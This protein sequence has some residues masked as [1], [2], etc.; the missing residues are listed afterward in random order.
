MVLSP[1]MSGRIDR[2][3]NDMRAERRKN[4]L[5]R[6]I[7]SY[8][9]RHP[10]GTTLSALFSSLRIKKSVLMPILQEVVRGG[11]AFVKSMRAK[12]GRQVEVITLVVNEA[13]LDPEIDKMKRSVRTSSVRQRIIRFIGNNTGKA[14]KKLMCKRLNGTEY[15]LCSELMRLVKEGLVI[16]HDRLP[17]ES[18]YE[19]AS[20]YVVASSKAEDLGLSRPASVD[21]K[22]PSRVRVVK[23]IVDFVK[24]HPLSTAED[25]CSAVS[26]AK[27]YFIRRMLKAMREEG[28]LRVEAKR[29]GR[30]GRPTFFYYSEEAQDEPDG[31]GVASQEDRGFRGEDAQAPQTDAGEDRGDPGVVS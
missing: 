10:K 21:V 23:A 25:V 17:Y 9:K 2:V 18:L 5:K 24:E 4:R 15:L 12:N 8:L 13:L 6:R 22:A 26:V 19:L 27:P 29:V 28:T 30:G 3:V 16:R 14:T 1:E 20:P 31:T 7:L 11:Y